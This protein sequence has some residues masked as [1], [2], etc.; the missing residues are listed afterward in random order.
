V[1]TL[2]AGNGDQTRTVTIAQAAQLLRV[3]VPTVRRKIKQGV[4]PATKVEGPNG[5]EYRVTLEQGADH[6][7]LLTPPADHPA[8]GHRAQ[9]QGDRHEQGDDRVDLSTLVA[10]VRDLQQQNLELA[11]RVGFYQNEIEH[12]RSELK[13]LQAPREP[14]APLPPAGA[15]FRPLPAEP[16]PPRRPWWRFWG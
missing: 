15:I 1:E 13:A 6:A 10:L 3:S 2:T 5:P 11:G 16:D 7:T 12:L 14:I 8:N 9:R 4:L